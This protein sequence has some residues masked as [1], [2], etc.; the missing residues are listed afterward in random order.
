[1]RVQAQTPKLMD[2]GGRR[3]QRSLVDC[4]YSQ[5]H[6]LITDGDDESK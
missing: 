6:D 5:T 3:S 2:A 4:F 1:M